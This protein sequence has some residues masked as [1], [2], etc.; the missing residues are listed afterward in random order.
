MP[1]QLIPRPALTLPP[2]VVRFSV[3]SKQAYLPEPSQRSLPKQKPKWSNGFS[4]IDTD[5]GKK[6]GWIVTYDLPSQGKSWL[7]YNG[8]LLHVAAQYNNLLLKRYVHDPPPQGKAAY[9]FVLNLTMINSISWTMDGKTTLNSL[10]HQGY[11]VLIAPPDET[12]K[13]RTSTVL[14]VKNGSIMDCIMHGAVSPLGPNPGHPIHK[15]NDH[16]WV[17]GIGSSQL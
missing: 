6:L 3:P 13:L 12:N 1:Q 17:L 10:N 11:S 9:T 15:R 4:Q 2:E 7:N 14:D 16:V 8:S 5:A